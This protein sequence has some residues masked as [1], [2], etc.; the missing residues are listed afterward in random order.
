MPATLFHYTTEAGLSE[1]LSS[2]VLYPS[3]RSQNPRD[4]RYGD[5]QYLSD[6][7]PG[8]KTPGQLAYLF[9]NDPRGWKRFVCF[10]EID[11]D[12]LTVALVKPHVYLI[13]NTQNLDLIHR[14]VSHGSVNQDKI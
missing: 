4:A 10:L 13:P 8:T 11:V 3:V 12:G 2:Q 6:L 1:I 7:P 14:I 5:G 9:L